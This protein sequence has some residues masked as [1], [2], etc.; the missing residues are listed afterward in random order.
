MCGPQHQSPEPDPR[1]LLSPGFIL[2]ETI[3]VMDQRGSSEQPPRADCI[4]RPPIIGQHEIEIPHVAGELPIPTDRR[5]A[6]DRRVIVRTIHFDRRIDRIPRTQGARDRA[7]DAVPGMWSEGVHEPYRPRLLAAQI[8]GR[9]DM[10][11]ADRQAQASIRASSRSTAAIASG[12]DKVG[13]CPVRGT[14]T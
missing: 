6:Y 9:M 14:V 2:V 13:A 10:K 1:R 5:L 3:L 4:H 8:E 12:S 7:D 11:D